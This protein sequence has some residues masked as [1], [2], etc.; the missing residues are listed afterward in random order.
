MRDIREQQLL[1]LALFILV[2]LS[3]AAAPQLQRKEKCNHHDVQIFRRD[4]A[5]FE[6]KFRALGGMTVSQ[7]EYVDAV[8]HASGLTRPCAECYGE[9]YMCGWNNC[10]WECS[11]AGPSCDKCL[12]EA[13]CIEECDK[14]TGFLEL[15]Q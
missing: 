9:A 5:H 6:A 15:V 2:S 4:G 12:Q 14:C 7:S 1:M 3:A 13:D 10:K 8:A 11:T